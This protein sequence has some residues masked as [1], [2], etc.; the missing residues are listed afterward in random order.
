MIVLDENLN[1]HRIVDAISAWFKGQVI[2]ITKLRIGSL[3]K[4]DAI[5]TLLHHAIQPTF[6]TI[7]VADFWKKAQPHRSYCII[8]VDVPEE[9]IHDVPKL[10]RRLFLLPDFKTKALRLGKV[11]HVTQNHIDY[12]AS[13]RRIHSLL[14]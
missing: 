9:R 7:N 12:Y 13:D 1:D 11:I 3:I 5:P 2:L 8:S 10:L 4:D 6:V 14:W